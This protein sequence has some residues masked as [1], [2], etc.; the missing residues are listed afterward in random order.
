LVVPV[1]R[2]GSAPLSTLI[3][4]YIRDIVEGCWAV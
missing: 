4:V 2:I 1:M 3:R